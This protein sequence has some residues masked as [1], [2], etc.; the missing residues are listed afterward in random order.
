MYD[1]RVDGPP[2]LGPVVQKL[3][4][5]D[6]GGLPLLGQV[7]YVVYGESLVGPPLLGPVVQEV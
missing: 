5:D 6:S 1:E 4:H 2:L 3:W 7:V